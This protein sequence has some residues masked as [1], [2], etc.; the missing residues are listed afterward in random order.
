MG[1]GFAKKKKQARQLQAQ[2]SML[3]ESLSSKLDTMEAEG[4]A[5]NGLVSITV[6]GSGEIK[7][8]RINPDCVD[9]E[10]IEGLEALIKAA[11]HTA[12]QKVQEMT[13]DEPTIQDL[14]GLSLLGM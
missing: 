9:K 10:D 8:V 5:G 4:N 14:P 12:F 13:K 3:Q 11:H 7:R 6:S 2:M 1:T